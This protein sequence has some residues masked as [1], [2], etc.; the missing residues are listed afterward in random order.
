MIY[1]VPVQSL[2]R[3]MKF[4]FSNEFRGKRQLSNLLFYVKE[5]KKS[6]LNVLSVEVTAIGAAPYFK[7]LSYIFQITKKKKKST[8]KQHFVEYAITFYRNFK[9]KFVHMTKLSYKKLW[10]QQQ[11]YNKG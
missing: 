7:A 6:Y 11:I 9:H 1:K 10:K 8:R 4:S 5:K 3:G 2:Y